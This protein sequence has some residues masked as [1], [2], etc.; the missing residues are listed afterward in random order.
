M[1]RGPTVGPITSQLTVEAPPAL[2]HDLLTDVGAWALWAP[3]VAS[4]VPARGH[5][6]AGWRLRVRPWFGPTTTMEVTEVIGGA[7]MR[8][9]TRG[10]GHLLSYAQLVEPEGEGSRVTFTATVTG[11]LGG[12]VQRL[13]A[14]LSALGQRR[15]LVRLA[16]TAEY[17]ARR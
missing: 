8:W 16:A 11:P 10:A 4:V 13:A 12:L 15:R 7:G 3:H 14:P 9:R 6:D 17:L 5:V 2:V 1:G